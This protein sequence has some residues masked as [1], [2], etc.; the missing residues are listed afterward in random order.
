MNRT[1]QNHWIKSSLSGRRH[2]DLQ[3]FVAS[4]MS[5]DFTECMKS[6]KS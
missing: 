1:K 6:T 3:L 4:M 2:F 5:N